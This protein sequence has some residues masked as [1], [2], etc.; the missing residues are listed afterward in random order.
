MKKPIFIFILLLLLWGI[1][2]F[3]QQHNYSRLFQELID[4]IP[5]HNKMG[6]TVFEGNSVTFIKPQI[7]HH[8]VAFHA[9]GSHKK[10]RTPEYNYVINLATQQLELIVKIDNGHYSSSRH[11]LYNDLL[12]CSSYGNGKVTFVD[13]LTKEFHTRHHDPNERSIGGNGIAHNDSCIFFT[14]NHH[15]LVISNLPGTKYLTIEAEQEKYL[16]GSTYLGV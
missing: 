5:Y 8:K 12:L 7:S 4:P 1:Y 2:W 10:N 14:P 15:S 13:V 11:F 6:T 3:I 16:N 9:I